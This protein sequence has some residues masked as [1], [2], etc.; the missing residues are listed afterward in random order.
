M[1]KT[2]AAVCFAALLATAATGWGSGLA[3]AEDTSPKNPFLRP[4]RMF[5]LDDKDAGESRESREPGDFPWPHMQRRGAIVPDER[6]DFSTFAEMTDEERAAAMKEAFS[7]RLAE[8]V[9]EGLLTQ[10]EADQMLESFPAGP[11]MDFGYRGESPDGPRMDFGFRGGEPDS[12][13]FKDR[14]LDGSGF[15]FNPPDMS[16]YEG[17]TEEER[18]SAMMEDFKAKLEKMVADG[19]ITQEQADQMLDHFHPMPQDNRI[20]GDRKK[21]QEEG[22]IIPGFPAARTPIAENTSV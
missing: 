17:M 21:P 13:G 11:H 3:F 19:D 15:R 22:R 2:I 7:A 20:P 14:E 16:K 4:P 5:D 10:E 8:K 6:P 18:A 9:A 1:N 12:F